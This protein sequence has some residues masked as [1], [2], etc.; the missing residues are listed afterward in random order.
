MKLYSEE[1]LLNVEVRK[2]II[3][4]IQST[5][6]IARKVEAKKRHEVYK[7]NTI[8]F[9]LEKLENEGLRPNTV[10]LMKNRASNISICRKVISKLSRSYQNGV[11]RE[12]AGGDETMGTKISL[13]SLLLDFNSNMKKCDRLLHLQKNC[14]PWFVPEEY[15]PG[16]FVIKFKVFSPE[17][18]DAIPSARDPECPIAIV[19]SEFINPEDGT[20]FRTGRNQV[21]GIDAT[22]R[23]EW[24]KELVAQGSKVQTASTQAETYIFWGNKYHFTCDKEGALIMPMSPPDLLNPIGEIPGEALAKDRDGKFW[25]GGGEDLADGSILINTMITDMNAIMFM[26]GWGQMVVTAQKGTVP[27]VLEGGP[28]NAMVFTYDGKA[29]EQ[30]PKLTIVNSNPPIDMWMKSIEQTTALLLSTNNLSPSSVAAKLDPSQMPSGIAMLIEKSDSTEDVKDSQGNFSKAERKL[31]KKYAKWHN[32]YYS[33]RE[34]DPEFAV[35]GQLPENLEVSTKFNPGS[36]VISEADKLG[37]MKLKKDLG[38]VREVDL[39][40]EDNPGMSE[41]EA[42]KKLLEIKKERLESQVS[43]ASKVADEMA[44]N[45]GGDG[46]NQ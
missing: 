1:Q 29:G 39:I 17:Q 18:Y 9:V 42:M 26:Q 45:A 30:E 7:D 37:N 20:K 31:W 25:A 24:Q 32:I 33:S 41:E 12:V 15:E 21:D 23:S 13:L 43:A 5:S 19:L 22:V 44:A 27:E 4:E 14:M 16:K 40:M 2:E 11:I 38:I 28:H 6:N 10:Q 35:A 3:K 34:L 36:E 8:K 46:G